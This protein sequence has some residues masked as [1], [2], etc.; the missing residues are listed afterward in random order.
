MRKEKRAGGMTV[1]GSRFPDE[2][3]TRIGRKQD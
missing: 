1:E 3:E 2:R